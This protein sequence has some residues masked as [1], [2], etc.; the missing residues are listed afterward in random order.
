MYICCM[1]VCKTQK[2][3]MH[4][5]Y[6]NVFPFILHFALTAFQCE[7]SAT[8]S[9]VIWSSGVSELERLGWYKSDTTVLSLS[10]LRLS[11]QG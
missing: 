8:L 1:C 7:L 2:H 3:S 6:Y 10:S 5:I 9:P 11:A 4:N